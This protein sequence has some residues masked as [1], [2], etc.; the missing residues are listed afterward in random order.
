MGVESIKMKKFFLLITSFITLNGCIEST[1]LLGPAISVGSSGN[2]YQAGLSFTSNQLLY[3]A[4]GK[5]TFDHVVTFLDP[6]NEFD[7]DL[8]LILNEK[9]NVVKKDL[10][11]ITRNIS[12]KNTEKS[13]NNLNSVIEDQFI[14]F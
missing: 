13:N 5:T 1:A 4:T 14:L 12:L 7:G 3:K 8:D 6:S 10:T 9:V 2:I 11:K